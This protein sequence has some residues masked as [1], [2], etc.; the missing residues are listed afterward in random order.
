[1]KIVRMKKGFYMSLEIQYTRTIPLKYD[2]DVLVVGG[3]PAG[4]AA[5]WSAARCGAKV[6]LIE[7]HAALGGMGTTGCL[8]MFMQLGD[9]VNF[10]AKGFGRILLHK[11]IEFHGIYP[12]K[13]PGAVESATC[14]RGEGL[15]LAYDELLT[16]AGVTLSLCT[17]L[18]DIKTSGRNVQTAIC[19]AKSG[20][21][22]VSAKVFVDCTGDGDLCA[23]AGSEY[24]KGDAMGNLMPGTLCSLY[25]GVDEEAVIASH[26]G[27]TDALRAA[28][29]EGMFTHSDLHL[30]GFGYLGGGIIGGNVSH[31]FGVDGTD[32]RSLTHHLIDSRK[33]LREYEAFYK[34]FYSGFD[35]M[36][37]LATGAM[38]GIRESRRIICDMTLELEHFKQRAVFEDEIGRYCYP[39]DVHIST[40][41]EKLYEQFESDFLKE[42]RYKP[43]ES[44]GIPYRCLIPRS[45]NNALVAGRCIGCD[46]YMLG[47]VRV[48]PGCFITGQAAGIG[49]AK[50]VKQNIAPRQV[51][52]ADINGV[53]ESFE[54][55]CSAYLS[56]PELAL[57]EVG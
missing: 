4:C 39:V 29:R 30:P 32:E 33:R 57:S 50:A 2:V 53:I 28:I 56:E 21:F 48:M 19:A 13:F 16:Q 43:G 3:G 7:G 18:I 25:A 49:A 52:V 40:P 24:E 23:W 55:E 44:Y 35:D 11:T 6:L 41:D 10:L 37:L 20:V 17:Q 5:A 31:A 54:E 47:S 46:R 14:I 12:E 36:R 38:M 45:L 9:G 27:K 15:K 42:Y 51:S 8:P 26:I 1:M 22:G 34:K